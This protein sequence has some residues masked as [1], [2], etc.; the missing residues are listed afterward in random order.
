VPARSRCRRCR[1][2]GSC[3][4]RF[5][6]KALLEEMVGPAGIE[7]ATLSLEGLFERFLLTTPV[8]CGWCEPAIYAVVRIESISA[9]FPRFLARV[10]T[11]F[12]TVGHARSKHSFPATPCPPGTRRP[13]V[14]RTIWL[15]QFFSK[16]SCTRRLL[17]WV[18]A[19]QGET[20]AAA[21]GW[22][23]QSS[24]PRLSRHANSPPQNEIP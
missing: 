5:A 1:R 13:R 15:R 17:Y 24:S 2:V 20:I 3:A 4:G 19:T 23:G 22:S 8:V 10:P 21:T 12:T 11:I 6:G 14:S 18:H 9:D 7:P 16:S